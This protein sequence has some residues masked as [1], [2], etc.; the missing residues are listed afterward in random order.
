MKETTESAC[1]GLPTYPSQTITEPHEPSLGDMQ[2]AM[3]EA[4]LER[5]QPFPLTEP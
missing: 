5:G 2:T 4:N 1:S 3:K